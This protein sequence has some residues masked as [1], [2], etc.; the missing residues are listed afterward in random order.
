MN[1][2]TVEG[3]NYVGTGAFVNGN[4][5][6]GVLVIIDDGTSLSDIQVRD[7][8][9]LAFCGFPDPRQTTIPQ[10]YTFDPASVDRVANLA[11][12]FGSVRDPNNT[13][14]PR[15]NLIEI[16][17]DGGVTTL[18]D[19]LQSSDGPEWDTLNVDVDIPAGASMLTVQALSEREDGLCNSNPPGLPASFTWVGSTLS[20]PPAAICGDGNLDPGEE[21]DDGNTV[22]GDGCRADCTEEICGDGILDPQEQCD[23]GNN[24]DGDGCQANCA[25]PLCGDGILDPG[26]ECDDGNAV[27]GDGC[28]ATCALEVCGNGIL[29]PGEECDDGNTIDGDGCSAICTVEISGGEG[30]TPGYWKQP[31]HFDSWTFPF[32]PDTLFSDVFEDAFPNMTLLQVLSQG[33]GGLNALGRHTVAALLNAASSGV[34]YDLPVNEVINS[35]NQVFPGTKSAY[36]T[37]KNNFE[38]FN[39]QGCPLN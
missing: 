34:D 36:N 4:H 9:D 32:T 18:V 22:D 16:T 6:A 35:F 25:L 24:I 8:V 38:S 20:V 7:G 30:C 15:P 11:M 26:E 28:S 10:M 14:E 3:L 1:T 2:L 17:V 19:P 29:D 31:H 27:D 37:L 33:G 21:C 13:G 39:E 23:D 12:F 5:G